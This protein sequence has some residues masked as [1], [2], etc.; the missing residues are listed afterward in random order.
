MRKRKW[1]KIGS[2]TFFFCF[3]CMIVN[4]IG[5]IKEEG[6][7]VQVFVDGYVYDSFSEYRS[8]R[9][10]R[11]FV[12]T[13]SNEEK[14]RF[15]RF[16]RERGETFSVSTHMGISYDTFRTLFS[17]FREGKG[18]LISMEGTDSDEM[19]GKEGYFDQMKKMLLDLQKDNVLAQEIILDPKKV[20]TMTIRRK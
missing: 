15:D 3:F 7:N 5:E 1:F 6:E 17:D 20:K 14:G 12:N 8:E 16:L 18:R 13:L 11:N 2:M 10:K 9:A 19:L 4:G